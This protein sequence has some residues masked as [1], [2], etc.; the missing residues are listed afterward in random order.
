[1]PAELRQKVRRARPMQ[2]TGQR[3]LEAQPG[4][5][6]QTDIDRVVACL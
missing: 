6:I 5:N 4:I 3:E 2:E 1:M